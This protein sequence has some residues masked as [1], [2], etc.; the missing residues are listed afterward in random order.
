MDKLKIERAISGLTK[1]QKNVPIES[2]IHEYITTAIEG[3]KAQICV[4]SEIYR[5]PSTQPWKKRGHWIPVTHGRGGHECDNC[6][7]Y[8]PSYQTGDEDLSDYCPSC[9]QYM[10]E[11]PLPIPLRICHT[12]IHQS[13]CPWSN[14]DNGYCHKWLEN[15]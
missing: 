7:N 4:E 10:K 3:L 9:G 12:C 5:L 8:A 13:E 15:I 11:G 1:W 2:D 14:T 6:H